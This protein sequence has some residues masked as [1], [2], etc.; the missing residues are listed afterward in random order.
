[1]NELKKVLEEKDDINLKYKGIEAE[2]WNNL[3]LTV[4]EKEKLRDELEGLRKKLVVIDDVLKGPVL[5]GILRA[6]KEK[7][8]DMKDKFL[9][10]KKQEKEKIDSEYSKK[11][12]YIKST[13]ID[14]YKEIINNMHKMSS[15]GNTFCANILS[16]EQL[17]K[18]I[19]L[20]DGIE[21]NM[22]EE[23]SKMD[24]GFAKICIDSANKKDLIFKDVEKEANEKG[25]S[26]EKY[27][28]NMRDY[29]PK[30]HN[31]LY[32]LK[33]E[34]YKKSDQ[35]YYDS[36]VIKKTFDKIDVIARKINSEI[37]INVDGS[38]SYMAVNS[39]E[40][41]KM[42]KESERIGNILSNGEQFADKYIE[43]CCKSLEDS[44]NEREKQAS[45]RLEKLDK[46][47]KSLNSINE[48]NLLD[49]K[50]DESNK[51]QYAEKL[52]SLSGNVDK[53]I[54]ANS[55][56]AKVEELEST[57]GKIEELNAN[58]DSIEKEIDILNQERRTLENNGR[59]VDIAI[60]DLNDKITNINKQLMPI[61]NRKKNIFTK[62]IGFFKGDGKN[63]NELID[64]KK[65]YE[66]SKTEKFTE[67]N[68]ISTKLN[69]N[70][71]ET[72]E[73]QKKVDAVIREGNNLI[74][75]VSIVLTGGLSN[76]TL[77]KETIRDLN[78]QKDLVEDKIQKEIDQ[79]TQDNPNLANK[80]DKEL[81]HMDEL[82]DKQ[83]Q[84]LN[85]VLPEDTLNKIKSRSD[86]DAMV[87][88]SEIEH[89]DED[90]EYK[91]NKEVIN[92]LDD[93]VR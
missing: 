23:L 46:H 75:N 10:D 7:A 33:S 54:S 38:S 27:V 5:K 44:I 21:T 48:N 35:I 78:N 6:V 28:D 91:I 16:I 30:L 73:K 12:E 42:K 51:E 45:D 26:V 55:Q 4:D 50:I 89:S 1:M 85:N 81:V 58:K 60:N 31:E 93:T 86:Y 43:D 18:P 41:E 53:L 2:L 66:E 61:E 92:K 25:I 34:I 72:S 87:K 63:Y 32:N 52:S 57:M 70:N 49:F 17:R 11:V 20:E 56:K 59:N 8:P 64:R 24:I 83:M 14:G 68:G 76:K 39:S 3:L 19:I 22:Y 90:V 80:S 13:G 82:I 29:N 47:D 40:L 65:C 74:S 15:S 62:M 9:Q 84:D 77:S 36:P 37:G 69:E 88:E 79:I 67:K 71:S